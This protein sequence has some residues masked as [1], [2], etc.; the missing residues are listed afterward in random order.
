MG[1]LHGHAGSAN[2]AHGRGIAGTNLLDSQGTHGFDF[3][4]LEPNILIVGPFLFDLSLD[5]MQPQA[6]RAAEKPLRQ[7]LRQLYHKT[8]CDWAVLH[9][10]AIG[11]IHGINYI[12]IYKL[13]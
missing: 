13:F 10:A 3:P 1:T 7:H 5:A 12:Y 2:G 8:G 9:G 4:F 11:L 6:C